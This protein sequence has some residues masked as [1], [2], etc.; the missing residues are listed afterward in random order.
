MKQ[1]QKND[2]D[3]PDTRKLNE[4][5]CY[6]GIVDVHTHLFPERLFRAIR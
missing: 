2:S 4:P 6:Q 3:P 5:P 1:P